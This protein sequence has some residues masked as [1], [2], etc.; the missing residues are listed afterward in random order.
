MIQAV[1]RQSFTTK[2]QARPQ[3]SAR[4]IRGDHN[5]NE[6]R[7]HCQYNSNNC[8]HSYFMRQPPTL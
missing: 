7:C 8:P 3:A 4:R 5:D 6:R 1:S 2:A